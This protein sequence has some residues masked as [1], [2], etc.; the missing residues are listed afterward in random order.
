MRK[1]N[2]DLMRSPKWKQQNTPNEMD[3]NWIESIARNR[4]N[5]GKPNIKLYWMVWNEM[6]RHH[7]SLCLKTQFPVQRCFQSI[8]IIKHL[9]IQSPIDGKSTR[10]T[11]IRVYWTFYLLTIFFESP[12]FLCKTCSYS[13]MQFPL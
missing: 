4:T 12:L 5:R 1:D 8:G 9:L 11:K 6:K 3:S 10:E 7:H 13:H 2:N